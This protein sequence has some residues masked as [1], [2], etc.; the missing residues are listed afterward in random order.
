MKADTDQ[1]ARADAAA[2]RPENAVQE[3][4]GLD[5]LN[6]VVQIAATLNWM[7]QPM[8]YSTSCNILRLVIFD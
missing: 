4:G 8:N 6:D 1:E 7:F 2:L 5:P 3:R